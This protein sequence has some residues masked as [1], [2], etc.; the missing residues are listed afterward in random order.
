MELHHKKYDT[1]PFIHVI[2][3]FKLQH[4]LGIF[5]K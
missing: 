2:L 4:Y 3:S 1:A 5:S